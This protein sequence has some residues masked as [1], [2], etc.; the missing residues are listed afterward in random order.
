MG[1][2]LRVGLVVPGGE[3][4]IFNRG[5]YELSVNLNDHLADSTR[6]AVNESGHNAA[7][8]SLV[9]DFGIDDEFSFAQ[10]LLSEFPQLRLA[11][12][13]LHKKV[14]VAFPS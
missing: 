11:L 12:G 4:W 2:L 10:N 1:F 13:L 14:G 3:S 9:V 8:S 7:V 5:S 6:C